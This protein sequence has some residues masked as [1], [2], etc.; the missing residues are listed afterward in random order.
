MSDEVRGQ[1]PNYNGQTFRGQ[2]IAGMLYIEEWNTVKLPHPVSA[3]AMYDYLSM[4]HYRG[5]EAANAMF[6][7]PAAFDLRQG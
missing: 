3:D 4:L 7:F 1:T 6:G 2:V 5:R